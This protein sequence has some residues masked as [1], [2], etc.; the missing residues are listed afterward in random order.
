MHVL[1]TG[2]SG[3][4]GNHL[5][6]A[7][8]SAGH[9]VTLCV[10]RPSYRANHPAGCQRVLADFSR[11]VTPDIW[12][13]RLA[14]IDAVINTVGIFRETRQQR[15]ANLHHK[16]PAALFKACEQAGIKRVIQVSALGADANARTAY[17]LSKRAADEVLCASGLEWTILRPSIVYARGAAS[18]SLF[19]G[20]AS[21]PWIPVVERGEQRIQPVHVADLVRAILAC[22]EGSAV[23]EIVNVIGPEPVTIR[24]LL[25]RLRVWLDGKPPHWVSV[26]RWLAQTLAETGGRL[27][28]MPL[29][30]DAVFMLLQDNVADVRPFVAHMGFEPR[31][32]DTV[33]ATDPATAADRWHARLYFLRPLLQLSIA[34]LWLWTAIV[35]AGVYPLPD[36]LAMLERTGI[37]QELAPLALAGAIGIDMFFGLAT[38]AGY[39]LS[40]L[41]SWQ[42]ALILFYTLI[43]TLFLPEYWAHPFG[44]L[45]KNIPILAALLVLRAITKP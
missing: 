40:V 26:P 13:P 5:V 44:P 16:A 34:V 18:W 32:L 2:A 45:I 15:F 36:S 22:L 24:E 37:P 27:F 3:F 12:L 19:L 17:H 28:R 10:R 21:L 23:C 7:L 29:G 14:G 31:R 38:L 35:S 4:I 30:R 41:L 33:L 43:I 11:D 42:I 8:L 39:R 6:H 20:L 25:G 1:V 9:R